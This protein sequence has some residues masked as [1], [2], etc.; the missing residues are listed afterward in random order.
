MHQQNS[1]SL[2]LTLMQFGLNWND[3]PGRDIPLQIVIKNWLKINYVAFISSDKALNT[4]R[5][6]EI[7]YMMCKDTRNMTLKAVIC[8]KFITRL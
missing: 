4:T 1:I 2:R 7:F 8:V 5:S 6:C 3:D